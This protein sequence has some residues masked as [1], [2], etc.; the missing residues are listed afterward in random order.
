MLI[1]HSFSL[2]DGG[3]SLLENLFSGLLSESGEEQ[4]NSVGGFFLHFFESLDAVT[5]LK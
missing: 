5:K 2:D 4:C 1:R 3:T